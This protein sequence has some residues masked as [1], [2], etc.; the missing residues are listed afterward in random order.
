MAADAAF[1]MLR[2]ELGFAPGSVPGAVRDAMH[3]D[4]EAARDALAAAGI[5]INETKSKDI[6]LQA[7][8]AAWLYRSGRTQADM[9][10]SLRLAIRNRQSAQI[11]G[12]EP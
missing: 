8:Y 12:T 1:A 4:L 6:R 2:T 11:V 7:A 10:V 3:V 9:P 5:V